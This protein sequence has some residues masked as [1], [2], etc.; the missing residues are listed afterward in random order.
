MANFFDIGKLFKPPDAG[1]PWRDAAGNALA[2][3]GA[4][5]KTL[6][7]YGDQSNADVSAL[8]PKVNAAT[9]NVLSL[10]G[11]R[12]NEADRARLI[13]QN[14][15]TVDTQFEQ[16][17][18]QL[19]N[20]LAGHNIDPTAYA[21]SLANLANH[22]A[23]TFAGATN[24]A[25]TTL[26]E[27]DRQHALMIQQMLDNMKNTSIGQRNQETGQAG[28][29]YQGQVQGNLEIAQQEQARAAANH[30]ALMQLISGA[31]SSFG[32][33]IPLL[34]AK[35]PAPGIPGAAPVPT[36]PHMSPDL[37]SQGVRVA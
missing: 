15:G 6:T 10:F 13:N 4:T 30:Q 25:T 19:D 18:A 27:Q 2:N 36:S 11:R 12:N 32:S 23:T 28:G 7:G 37:Y 33:L 20:E 26:D 29:L 16:Q 22:R 35:T 14:T 31:G 21:G 5:G 24:N 8:A 34:T 17:K 3:V 9:D 1:G